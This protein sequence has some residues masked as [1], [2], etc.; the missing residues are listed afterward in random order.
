MLDPQ[1]RVANWNAGAQRFKGYQSQEIIG[2]H[3]SV[4]YTEEDRF[5]DR[6]A[7]ALETALRM[8]TFEN[9]GWRVR[10]NGERFWAHVVID[11]L[12][13]PDGTVIG[14]AKIT[15]DL[16][17]RKKAELSLRESAEQFKL[18]VQSVTDYAIYM[19]SPGGIVSSWNAG[20]ERIKGYAPG[21]IIGEHF[22]K[23]YT[24]EDRDQGNP[25]KALS[26]ALKEGRFSSEGWRLRKDGTRFRASVVIDPVFTDDGVLAGYAKIT[27][28]VTE[29]DDAQRALDE[30]RDAVF[31]AQKME[32]IGRFTGGVAHD[33][34]NL[35]T[36][37]LSS[38]ALLRKRI[39]EDPQSLKLLDNAVEGAQRGA[40][41]TQRMLA[42]ARRQN[43][44]PER[45]I[46]PELVSGMT[47]LLGQSLGSQWAVETRFPLR[48]PPVLVDANQLEM[49]LLNLVTNARDAM[50]AG[51]I[52]TIAA[53]EQIVDS[54]EIPDLQNGSY[55]SL[56]V[57]DTGT[58]M[59]AETLAMATDP[60][61]TTKGIGKGTGLG[62]SMIQG[63]AEQSKGKIRI[64]SVEGAGTTVELL[65]PVCENNPGTE[66][67]SRD[68]PEVLETPKSLKI[69][70]VDD[71]RLVLMNT[72]MVL[73]ELGHRVFESGSGSRALELFAEHPDF[74]LVITDQAMPQIT[75]VQLAKT[76]RELSPEIPI[77]IA[78]GYSELASSEL[79]FFKL[80]KPFT[81]FEL[82]DAISRSLKMR[83]Y[84]KI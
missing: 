38:L 19:L 77:I 34:N 28:D 26:I 71:D 21:E 58:G 68:K 67:P 10:K 41:L 25:D 53:H 59:D 36:A 39:P 63:L 49:A 84:N 80:P 54:Q 83:I 37:V 42:F 73:E 74:D 78:T 17:E 76:I 12:L 33:F 2:A 23:F 30:A 40:T 3:F 20:A 62:L 43:L 60:F 29:R 56:S 64:E 45:V 7:Q 18:L 15:R 31:Q 47:A 27:R 75:G 46:L 66:P 9:E 50:P 69:L 24:Q 35:L 70:A 11:P 72:R 51:G 48:M 57:S 32:V 82:R 1:G 81:E 61:F 16:T 14:Y 79:S 8:G 13:E 44:T 65:L 5:A 4:F 6:P 52:I 22:S 55:V